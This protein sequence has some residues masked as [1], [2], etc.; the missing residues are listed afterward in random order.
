VDR[1]LPYFEEDLKQGY[2]PFIFEDPNSYY[3]KISRVIGKTI[4]ED[5]ANYYNLKT[6]NL[7]YFKKLLTYLA[8]PPREN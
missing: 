3:E 8:S 6:P 2:Y 7:Q 5:I 1:I 4:F